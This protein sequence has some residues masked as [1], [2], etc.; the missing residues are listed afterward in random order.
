MNLNKANTNIKQKKENFP[1]FVKLVKNQFWHGG[2][3]YALN[4]KKEFLNRYYNL[5][6]YI[7]QIILQTY[8]NP[9]INKLKAVVDGP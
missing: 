2:T 9:V 7:F 6:D 1:T 4:E 3:K 8:A 5:Q